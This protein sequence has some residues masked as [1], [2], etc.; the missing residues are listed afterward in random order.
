MEIVP[1][2]I[3]N[4]KQTK[5][6]HIFYPFDN[7]ESYLCNAV[8]FIVTAA[9][10]GDHVMFIENDRN[11]LYI[12]KILQKKLSHA[13][14]AKVHIMNNFDFYYSNGNFHPHTVLNYFLTSIAPHQ[15]AG[16][17]ICTWGLIEWGND[18]EIHNEIEKYER[19]LNKY[20][21]NKGVISVC[22]YDAGRT[23]ESLKKL[24][25]ECHGILLT[26]KEFRFLQ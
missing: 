6:G 22:A 3:K 25:M 7:I 9:K 19:E 17:S 8:S 21:L 15:E 20:I 13:E 23:P 4:L 26:D 10:N 5:G 2:L 18:Q 11:L 24:L 12:N 1:E 16:D 14:M